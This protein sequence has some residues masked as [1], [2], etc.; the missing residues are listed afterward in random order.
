[1]LP[2]LFWV[3]LVLCVIGLFVPLP[4][5]YGPKVPDAVMLVLIFLLGLRVFHFT[6]ALALTTMV[7]TSC[8]ST[9]PDDAIDQ[10]VG[11]AI[12]SSFARQ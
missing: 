10:G 5:P 2:I 9:P 6:M 4:G 7:A 3:L 1:M 11:E 12:R 8:T